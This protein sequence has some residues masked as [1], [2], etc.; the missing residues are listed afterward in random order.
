MKNSRVVLGTLAFIAVV[1]MAWAKNAVEN[2]HWLSHGEIKAMVASEPPPP[3]PGSA[4]DKA[5]IQAEVA[6][7]NGRGPAQIAE[8]KVDESY[9]ITL[10][11]DLVGPK[12][13]PQNDPK[14]FRFFDRVNRQ[15]AQVVHESKDHWRRPRPYQ[16][17]PD[18]IHPLFQAGDYSYPS[19]HSTHS[20]AFAEVLGELFPDRAKAFLD[21]AHQI[22]QSRV[23]AGVHYTTDIKEGEVV[24]KEI[25]KELLTKPEFRQEL[26]V[27]KAEV[28]AQK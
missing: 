16:A 20:F 11:T 28:A 19:G 24:G 23:D 25:A 12:I 21:R 4:A 14:T 22:A 1:T 5:D 17:H 8:A 9:S 6:A 10:F 15:I 18:L 26:D 3:A 7:Q 2:P 13:T 27:A